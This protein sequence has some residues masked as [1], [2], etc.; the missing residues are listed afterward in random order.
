MDTSK[1][2][3]IY[4]FLE[5]ETSEQ[6]NSDVLHWVS[7]SGENQEEFRKIHQA[8]HISSLNRMKS[9]IDV[10][11]AWNELKS[12]IP[13]SKQA[14]KVININALLRFA[15]SILV[16]LSVGFGSFWAANF[17]QE[18]PTDS[19][20]QFVTPKGEKS[21]VILAD[22]SLVWLNSQS[23]LKYNTLNP[24]EVNLQGE[25]FFEVEKSNGK[26]FEVFTA[27]G[28]K[29][30]V[31]G[32]KFNL[33]S[34]P[35]ESIVETTLEEGEVILEGK[36]AGSATVLSPGQQAR[37]NIQNHEISV[38]KVET[39]IYSLWR[40]NELRFENI[41]LE[42][43]VPRIEQWYGVDITLESSV[44]INDRFTLTIK[45]ES[46]RELLNMMQLTSKFNYEING[47][48]VEIHA[49]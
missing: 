31:T 12:R 42:E 29:I 39:E 18:Q 48:S 14:P 30:K 16:I 5:R 40:K 45:T 47:S 32:T 28:V 1:E 11:K 44:G 36:N 35:H 21:K 17:F 49:K 13:D 27:S 37:Y 46:L 33:R 23:V 9:E 15:A 10:D 34:Y 22:G 25:A 7:A 43:L 19:I 38:E 4:R 24:R 8:V 41:S 26:P 20:V 3:L 6:E 2:N